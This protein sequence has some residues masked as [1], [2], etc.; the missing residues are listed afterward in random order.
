M[1]VH[2]IPRNDERA[3]TREGT[4]CWCDPHVTWID[5]DT[6]LPWVNPGCRVLHRAADCREASEHITGE[7]VEDDKDWEII[8]AD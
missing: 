3:H 8:E 5:P 4:V 1:T 6:D 2:C 7:C